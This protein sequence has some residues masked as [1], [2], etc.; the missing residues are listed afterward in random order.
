MA[1]AI[2]MDEAARFIEGFD[3]SLDSPR[4]RC[5]LKGP[6]KIYMP[7]PVEIVELSSILEGSCTIPGWLT[8]PRA[9]ICGI[10]FNAGEWGNGR[11]RCSSV[12]CAVVASQT[13]YGRI[14]LFFKPVQSQQPGYAVVSWFST[15]SYPCDN[16]LLVVCVS[17]C[18]ESMLGTIIPI[19]DIEPSQILIDRTDDT[20]CYVM[21]IQG[22]DT[23]K[24]NNL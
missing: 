4:I 7:S 21:R 20:E 19:V 1:G 10:T 13:R 15:P 5:N 11:K 22:Y 17:T 8:Y 6:P 12:F 24:T 16:N 14:E 23:V 9:N 2:V 18:D 3:N